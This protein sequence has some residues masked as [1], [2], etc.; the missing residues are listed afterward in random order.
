VG[1]LE[2]A[3]S[4]ADFLVTLVDHLLVAAIRRQRLPEREQMLRPVVAHQRLG[5]HFF[6]GLDALVPQFR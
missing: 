1:W 3:Q 5:D 2:V 4:L 6:A